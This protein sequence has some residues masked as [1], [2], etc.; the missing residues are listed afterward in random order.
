MKKVK[1]NGNRYCKFCK[2]KLVKNGKMPSGKQRWFCIKCNKSSTVKRTVKTKYKQLKWFTDWILNKSTI[3]QIS[4][5]KIRTFYNNIKWCWN[6][7]PEIKHENKHCKV[8][9]VDAIYIK[10]N[11]CLL[12]VRNEKYVISY[13]WADSEDL[14]SYIKLFK[15]TKEPKY[16][17][18]DGNKS[19]IKAIKCVYNNTKIQR[20]LFHIFLFARQK[21]SLKP[22]T[23][24]GQEL[25]NI[26]RN[27][28]KINIKKE[29]EDWIMSYL[30][31]ENSYWNFLNERTLS[32]DK[33]KWWYTH[34]NIRSVRF[35]IRYALENRQLF[36]FI[37]RQIPKTSNLV[38][39]GINARLKE[40]RRCHRGLNMDKQ[41]RIFE[42]YLWSRNE[43]KNLIDFL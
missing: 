35:H 37:N 42:W 12:I 41:K 17:I 24:C 25:L 16:I 39:G 4:L 34:K 43:G 33:V 21:L 23:K 2:N 32:D 38:E 3:K 28:L 30:K 27:L 13:V 6:I 19:C 40:L 26:V 10:R 14:S 31:W 22:E 11:N 8:I 18:T 1:N 5:K 7:K 29:A 20:C 9:I 15:Q 36:I